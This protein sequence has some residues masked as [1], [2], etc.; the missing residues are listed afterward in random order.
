[1]VLYIKRNVSNI[2]KIKMSAQNG[3]FEEIKAFN[4]KREK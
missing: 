1:M 2:V 3:K 4:I